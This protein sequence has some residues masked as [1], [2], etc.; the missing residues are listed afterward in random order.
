MG[1]LTGAL[2]VRRYR[3]EEQVPHEVRD[4][5]TEALQAWAFR[6]SADPVRR[7]DTEGWVSVHNLL[8]ADFA[9]SDTWLFDHYAVFALRVDRKVLPARLVRALLQKRVQAWSAEH[10]R[11]RVPREV[12]EEMQEQIEI[13]LLS[14]SLPRV[15]VYEVCWDLTG[16]WLLFH[17]LGEGANERFRTLFHRTFGLAPRVE[18]PLDLVAKEVPELVDALLATGGTDLGGQ[19]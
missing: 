8:D 6:P 18:M 2:T 10:G 11:P 3:V 16:G 5:Y 7:T 9:D 19:G 1:V 17:H 4:R 12:R 15:Q 14:R 13:D